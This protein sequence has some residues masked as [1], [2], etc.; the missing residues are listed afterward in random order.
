MP[1][2]FW[3]IT[4]EKSAPPKEKKT[5]QK[6]RET[7]KKQY[8]KKNLETRKTIFRKIKDNIQKRFE[9]LEISQS[10]QMNSSH[11]TFNIAQCECNNFKVDGIFGRGKSGDDRHLTRE[12]CPRDSKY[13]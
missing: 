10:Q 2:D 13:R 8:L 9:M 11:N 12:I 6:A 5:K 4:G 3:P 7:K 1:I